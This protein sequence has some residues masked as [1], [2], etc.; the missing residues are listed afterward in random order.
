MLLEIDILQI[1]FSII[2]NHPNYFVTENAVYLNV[3]GNYKYYWMERKQTYVL[4]HPT[5]Q[6]QTKAWIN[7]S[8]LSTGGR[9]LM[10]MRCEEHDSLVS[11]EGRGEIG[12]HFTGGEEKSEWR[13]LFGLCGMTSWWAGL[14]NGWM[15]NKSIRGYTV[16]K[17]ACLFFYHL[18]KQWGLWSSYLCVDKLGIRWKRLL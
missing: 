15:S 2:E 12:W 7:R 3:C 16:L 5:V 13:V 10:V 14:Y 4:G 8:M 1:N 18:Q 6:A 9:T 17:K 11:T